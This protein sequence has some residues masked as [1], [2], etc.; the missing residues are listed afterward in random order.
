MQCK[1]TV[2]RLLS[3]AVECS[4]AHR[5]FPEVSTHREPC[6]PFTGKHRSS[7]LGSKHSLF[8]GFEKGS[9]ESGE[10]KVIRLGAMSF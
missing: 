4:P 7:T 9:E 6:S 8:C 3:A 5:C 2:P 10:K 1:D